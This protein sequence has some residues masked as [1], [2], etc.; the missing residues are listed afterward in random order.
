MPSSSFLFEQLLEEQ[1]CRFFLKQLSTF[2]RNAKRGWDCFFKTKFTFFF[3]IAGSYSN[4][5]FNFLRNWQTLFQ[6][7]C[8]ILYQHDTYRNRWGLSSFTSSPTFLIFHY[9]YYI[10]IL[11]IIPSYLVWSGISL[12]GG[13]CFL[14]WFLKQPIFLLT[15]LLEYNCFTLFC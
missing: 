14:L 9:Y 1:H 5:T 3:L 10:I 6:R 7:G 15:S 12:C 2:L 4:S 11:L 8:T 13:G